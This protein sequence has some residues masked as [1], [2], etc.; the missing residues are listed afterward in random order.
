MM[1]AKKY[2]TLLILAGFVYGV[3]AILFL[4]VLTAQEKGEPNQA[5]PDDTRAIE[6]NPDLSKKLHEAAEETPKYNFVTEPHEILAGLQGLE[7]I[8]ET[9]QPEVKKYNLTEQ[10]LRTAVESRLHQYGIRMLSVEQRL[11]TPGRSYLYISVTP[12]ILEDIEFAAVSITV[13]LRELIHLRRNPTT[14]VMATTWDTGQVI[15]VEKNRFESIRD[16]IRDLVD[17]FINTYL[18]ANPTPVSTGLP[19]TGLITGITY[20]EEKSFAI[21]G[22]K[23]VSEGETIDG[24]KIIKIHKDKVEFEKDGKRWTQ[25]L[26][27]SSSPQWQQK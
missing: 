14:I 10:A 24:I 18:A 27:E 4:P 19:M 2:L 5:I 12:V 23:I 20:N 8:V 22:T 13:K 25:G 3:C 11:Q 26:N 16:N 17:E 6:V 21:I 1:I 9:L 15:L 7:V